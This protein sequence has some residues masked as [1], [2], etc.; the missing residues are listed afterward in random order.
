LP[1]VEIP[2]GRSA[3]VRLRFEEPAVLSRGDRFILR[4]YSPPATIAGGL[5]LDPHPA[6]GA[7]RTPSSLARFGSLD[8]SDLASP[9]AARLAVTTMV[10]ERGA[11]GLPV[12]A[13]VSRAGV[14]PAGVDALVGDLIRSG[15]VARVGQT[16][17]SPPVLDALGRRVLQRLGDHHR[18]EPLAEGMP[19]EELR[20]REFARAG[21]GVFEH[22]LSGLYEAGRIAGRDRVALA[23][24]R[25]SLSP[26]EEGARAACET[27]FREAGL[28]PPDPKE[29][30]AAHGVPP[31]VM[32]RVVQLLVRQKIL[33]R[34]EAVYFHQSA[35]DRLKQDLRALKDEAAGA[36]IDVGTFKARYDVSRKFAIPLL[37]YLDRERVTRRVGDA[38]VLI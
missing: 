6:R 4:A 7:I 12:A 35:L 33:V 24:H 17:V 30:A 13:L 36:R 15:A 38:R 26:A 8:A 29:V 1:A 14:D 28:R 25:V 19:R 2:G 21:D 3:Y 10:D 23:S 34:L 9:A 32:A 5:V 31:E 27:A 20:E 18:S 22:V 16:L 11:G 37:E